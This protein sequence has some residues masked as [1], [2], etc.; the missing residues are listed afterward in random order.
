MAMRAIMTAFERATALV[1]I[2]AGAVVL[3]SLGVATAA[4]QR[5]DWTNQMNVSV[6]GNG[7]QKTSGCDGCD[8]ATAV[9]RQMI[10]SGDGYVEFTVGEPYTFWMAGLSRSDGNAHFNSIDFALRFNGNDSA[11]VMENGR[12]QGGDM[13]YTAGDR[14]R[15]AVVRD[16]VQYMKNGSVFF[17]S[18][19]TPDRKSVV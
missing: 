4:E 19:Q 18:R 1:T 16:R 2:T 9:S 8:D 15:I 17:E 5:V 10:R 13:Y 3:G 14:F 11:D 12:Y 7:L 6:R